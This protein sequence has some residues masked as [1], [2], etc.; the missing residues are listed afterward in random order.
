[1]KG[2]IARLMSDKGFGFIRPLGEK[3]RNNDVFFH[4]TGCHTAFGSLKEGDVVTYEEVE[5]PKGPRAEE[6]EKSA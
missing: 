4:S 1:M 3:D 5:S 6:V 2:T